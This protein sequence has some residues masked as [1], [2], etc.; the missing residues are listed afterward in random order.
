MFL[1]NHGVSPDLRRR[2][3]DISVEFF[4]LPL[5]ERELVAWDGQGVWNGWMPNGGV[6][7]R[8]GSGEPPNLVEWYMAHELE[9]FTNWPQRP[10]ELHT[11]WSEYYSVMADLAAKII[12]AVASELDLPA[13][14][15]PAW[16]DRHFANLCLNHYPAQVEPPA[17]GQV[18]LSPHT[19]EDTISI[20]TAQDAPGG[21]QVRMPGRGQWTSVTFPPEAFF[22]Q[23]GD[24]LDRWTNR[25]IRASIHRV[26]NPPP[27]VAS[28]AQRNTVIFFHFP[29]LD[30]VVAPAESCVQKTGG[31]PH[32]EP[33][34]AWEHVMKRQDSYSLPDDLQIT[35]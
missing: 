16:T 17:P 34:T 35:A 32:F 12:S 19:D 28:T 9:T 4:E 3:I 18:R 11:V 33:V 29:A 1:T 25:R 26:A 24:L 14:D 5:E 23:A 30:T 21:L 27:Q 22:V 10:A 7:H 2:M 15:V 13:D 31:T 20:L 8:R 6:Y